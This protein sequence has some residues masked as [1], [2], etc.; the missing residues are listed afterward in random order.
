MNFIEGMLIFL[1]GVAAGVV[2]GLLGICGCIVMF[3]VLT[4]ILHL[5]IDVAVGTNVTAA[6]FTAISGAVAHIKLRNVEREVVVPVLLGGV[7][8]AVTGSV[9]FDFLR[10]VVW[11]LYIL[12]SMMFLYISTRMILDVLGLSVKSGKHVE[13]TI[14]KFLIGLA[15]GI[16]TGLFGFGGGYVMVPSFIY[17]LGLTPSIAVGTSLTSY[18]AML[19][20]SST[21][22]I[23]EGSVNTLIAICLGVGTAAGA[24]IGARLVKIAPARALKL[25]FAVALLYVSANLLI[26]GLSY[27]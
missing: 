3:P 27:L 15:A 23:A 24:Q 9:V 26:K 25:I 2:G 13:S 12:T 7:V 17:L 11:S 6:I 20:V 10:R 21:F 5:P 18:T 1:T 14:T 19:A 4:L 22:K 16:V 8:G